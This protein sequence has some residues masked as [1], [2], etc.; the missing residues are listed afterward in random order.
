MKKNI[1]ILLVSACFIALIIFLIQ[2]GCA[3][4]GFKTHNG[5]DS[6]KESKEEVI[7]SIDLTPA[8]KKYTRKLRKNY[9]RIIDITSKYFTIKHKYREQK[10]YFS[11][12]TKVY[13]KKKT[14]LEINSL[15]LCQT[16]RVL[17]LKGNIASKIYILRDSDCLKE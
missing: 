6:D 15:E 13:D 11:N 10:F 9:G 5:I 2:I 14:A 17:M 8:K 16:V 3:E 1:I 7:K 12:K 4:N